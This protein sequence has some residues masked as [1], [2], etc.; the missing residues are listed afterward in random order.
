M[1]DAIAPVKAQQLAV[2]QPSRLPWNPAFAERYGIDP[3]AWKALVEAVF[4]AA[5]T[6]DAVALAL[7]YCKARRLDPFKRVVHIVPVWDEEKRRTVETVWPGIAAHRTTA[8]RTGLY[9]G[10]DPASYGDEIEKT[11]SGKT[12]QGPVN[13]TVRFPQWCQ[14]TVYRLAG[15]QRVSVPGPRVYWEE[16]YSQIGRSGVPNQRWQR[17]PY[18][19]AEKCAEAAALRRAFPEELGE[20]TTIE[21]NRYTAD[22]PARPPIGRADEG[23]PQR[24]P[25]I[26]YRLIDADGV[27]HEHETAAAA[28][29]ALKLIFADAARR[30]VASLDAA[31]EHNAAAIQ[32][33][34]DEGYG[35]IA[36]GLTA[37]FRRDAEAGAGREDEGDAFGLKPLPAD[38]VAGDL[39][40]DQ[41]N[42]AVPLPARPKSAELEYF[43]RQL[44]ALIEEAPGDRAR[45]ARIRLANETGLL[46]LKAAQPVVYDQAMAAMALR[47]G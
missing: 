7:S 38:R 44:F 20:E 42:L 29:K 9:A 1:T 6:A 22:S 32:R 27:E 43:A 19:M 39:L 35:V 23:E 41:E 4:P 34:R 18:Q 16:T 30:N 5:Q 40:G 17:A 11:F 47:P 37:G 10:A 3:A 8:M 12:Q 33:L 31:S 14:I 26:A 2:L 45:M 46:A 13:A 21:E 15:A 24:Q 36:D 28:S 25:D